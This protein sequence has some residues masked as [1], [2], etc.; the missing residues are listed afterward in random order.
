MATEPRNIGKP[1]TRPAATTE[2]AGV[3]AAAITA[4]GTGV[5]EVE[6]QAQAMARAV[7]ATGASTASGAAAEDVR[8][9]AR[10]APGVGSGA[11]GAT[12]PG[13]LVADRG[14]VTRVL[15]DFEGSPRLREIVRAEVRRVLADLTGSGGLAF[16]SAAGRD[17]DDDD[18]DFDIEISSKVD[19]FRRA[20]IAHPATPTPRRSRDF[21]PE[22]L[23][24]LRSE[25]N[26]FIRPRRAS[27]FGGVAQR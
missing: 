13:D 2:A 12:V 26:L 25:P 10:E 5:P 3:S 1:A 20:G 4:A 21:T 22:Q 14:L 15:A 17:H 16:G 19:G 18:D 27:V 7:E 11:V 6:G 9:S 8:G 23:E 24:A